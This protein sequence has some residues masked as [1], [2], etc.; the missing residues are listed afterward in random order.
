MA[1]Y[2]SPRWS[3]EVA[4][5]SMPMTFDQYSN[6]SFKCVYCFSYFQR[7]VNLG[8]RSYL[9]NEYKCVDVKRIKKIFTEPETSQ[10]GEYIRQRKVMQWGGLSDPFCYFEKA[11][12]RNISIYVK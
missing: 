5:C 6:C 8:S 2:L 11:D 10:F 9:S 4:D 7:A 1:Y 3:G 12:G